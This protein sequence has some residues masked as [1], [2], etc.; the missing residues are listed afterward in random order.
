MVAIAGEYRLSD[1]KTITPLEAMADARDLIRWVR[2]QATDLSV[3]PHRIAAYGVSAGAHLALSAAVFPHI[4]EDRTSAV[5][6]MLILVSPPVSLLNDKWPQLLLGTRAEVKTISPAENITQRLPPILI[7]EGDA[8]TVTPALSARHFCDRAKQLEGSCELNVYPKLGHIL[9]R[10]LD[11]RA[12]EEGPFDPDP[13]A[14]LDAHVK[15]EAFLKKGGFL[16]MH[17]E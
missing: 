2:K 1:Q 6:D 13:D 5:P 4:E 11:P 3:D 14:V 7:I 9:S 12:Q 10:N 8:D 17:S 16:R 15:V